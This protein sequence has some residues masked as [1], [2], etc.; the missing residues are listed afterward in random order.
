MV[1]KGNQWIKSE[2]YQREVAI[3]S[4]SI[5]IKLFHLPVNYIAI[6]KISGIKFV[7]RSECYQTDGIL[8]ISCPMIIPLIRLF[9][10]YPWIIVPHRLVN[11]SILHST[12]TKNFIP[13]VHLQK[14]GNLIAKNINLKNPFSLD[15]E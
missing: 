12:Q 13:S 3:D 4:V 8:V 7:Q 9:P 5:R 1:N 14:K 15:D 11:N 2:E 10:G 6:E